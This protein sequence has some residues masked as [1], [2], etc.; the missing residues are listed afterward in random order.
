MPSSM[1]HSA[2]FSEGIYSSR[3]QGLSQSAASGGLREKDRERPVAYKFTVP[4]HSFHTHSAF[5]CH[6]TSGGELNWTSS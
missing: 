1:R 2:S 4:W 3:F 6:V 5:H